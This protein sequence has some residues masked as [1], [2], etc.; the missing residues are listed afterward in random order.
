M[1]RIGDGW[2]VKVNVRDAPPEAARLPEEIDGVPE[3][4]LADADAARLPQSSA[5]APWVCVL[6][7]VVWVHR[8]APGARAA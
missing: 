1:T 3:S 2:G 8:A 5:P 7:A 6:D 4:K